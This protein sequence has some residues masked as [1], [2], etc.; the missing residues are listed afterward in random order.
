MLDITFYLH[1]KEEAEAIEISDDFY[2]W[3]A[4]SEF[5]KIGQ[6]QTQ[7]ITVDG[8]T[9][10]ISAIQ[11]EGMNRR[12]FSD[13]FRNAIVQESDELLGS[14]GNSSSKQDY[15]DATYRLRILQNLRKCIENEEYKYFQRR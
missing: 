6:P 8:E 1:N 7:E 4:Q 11:L 2:H 10:L 14:L 12:K 9:A 5:S 3:L 13:F 15:Q